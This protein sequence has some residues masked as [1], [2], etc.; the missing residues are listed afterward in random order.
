M[1]SARPLLSLTLILA[2]ALALRLAFLFLAGVNAPLSGDE[3]AYQQIAVNL[4]AG[5]GFV[6][7]NNPFFPGQDL[8]AWQAPLYPLS[9]GLL[10]L[11]TGPSPLVGKLFGI[12][13]GV[14]TVWA[15]F[16][17]TRRVWHDKRRDLVA[18][19]AALI[20]AVYPGFLTNAHLLLSETLFTLLLVLAFD[21]LVAAAQRNFSPGLSIAAGVTWGLATLTRGITLYA[22]VPLALW[23]VWVGRDRIR[24]AGNRVWSYLQALRRPLVAAGLFVLM[25][26]V[27][28]A[29]WTIRNY[30][31][32]KQFVPLETKGGV[33]F[34][35]GNSPFT[36]GDFIRNV[37]KVGVREPMLAV[38][39]QDEIARDRAAYA[40]GLNYVSQNPFVFIGRMPYKFA[41]FW[42]FERNLVDVADAT[43]ANRSGGWNSLSK[44]AAD[45]LSDVIYVL[46]VLAAVG[47]L[48]LSPDNRYKLLIGGFMLYFVAVHVAV[49]GDARFHFPLIPFLAMYAAWFAVHGIRGITR[50]R[51]AA[52]VALGLIFIAV[53][54]HELLAAIHTLNG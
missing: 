39:P 21:L 50:W 24:T 26:I 12:V 40:L 33:N 3:P 23:L 20:V 47:G 5:R 30:T 45:F 15:T 4:A 28:I 18:L 36:P 38:L 35:L 25:T 22:V 29:P 1:A 7:N 34:W 48:V 51:A 19:L 10:Y 31:V 46:V 17:L 8:Y 42:G 9:L 16:D 43:H 52:I 14:A 37:W 41:D 6:Q 44:I 11:L 54:A 27:V 53:W 2:L 13:V 49:F 32:F